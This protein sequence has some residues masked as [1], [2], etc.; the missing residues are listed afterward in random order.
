[1][2][3]KKHIRILFWVSF[4]IFV[5]NKFYL[6]PWVL[7][8]DLPNAFSILVF[9]IPNLIEVILGITV[10]TGILFQLKRHFNNDLKDILIY[11][12]SALLTA[13]YVISQELG[14]HNIGGNNVY[15]YYDIIAS[16]LGLILM[17]GIFVL[18]GFISNPEIKEP[19]E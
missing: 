16:V 5:L 19:V 1:M 13:F 6:R 17:F 3:I 12:I 2:R 4:A 9:S 11:L 18:F 14:Y 15:D 8:S 10:I 7:E